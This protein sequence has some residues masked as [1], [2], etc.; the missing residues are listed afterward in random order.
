MIAALFAAE[1]AFYA[2]PLS[3]WRTYA[4]LYWIVCSVAVILSAAAVALATFLERDFRCLPHLGW[5][6]TAF[7]LPPVLIL[8][9]AGG[10]FLTHVDSEGLQQLADG[11]TLLRLDVGHGMF[12]LAHNSYPARQ[13]VLNCLPTCLLGP[14]LWAAR[15][16]NSAFYIASY[17]FFLSALA[18]H[19]R[20]RGSTDPLLFAAYC[21]SLIALGQYTLLNARQFEQTTMPIGATLFF[22]GAVL[23]FM[24]GPEPLRLLWVTWAFGFFPEC[25]T[26]ALGGF[27]LACAVLAYL[28]ILGRRWIFLP[29]A[30]YGLLCL[31]IA[32]QVA[33]NRDPGSLTAKFRM[34]LKHATAGD[35]AFRYSNGLRAVSGG[36]YSLLPAP[37]ALAVLAALCLALR[38]REYRYAA[39]CAWAGAVSFLSIALFGSNLNIPYFDIQRAMIIIPPLALGALFLFIRFMD[40]PGGSPSAVGTVKFLMEVSVAYMAFTGV[41]TVL[42]V[43]SFFGSEF[44]SEYDEVFA[45]VNALVTSPVAVPPLRIYLVPPLDA[46]IEPG[47]M[48]FAPEARVFRSEPPAGEKIAGAYVFSYI[49]KDAHDRSFDP[50]IPSYHLQPVI[51]MAR[52]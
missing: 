20:S 16:G 1:A 42:L 14:S 36:D 28:I 45:D 22:L 31:W 9:N 25:Y 43:R 2:A 52:E 4:G 40:S 7:F 39:V 23:Y 41:C 29:T 32:L 27:V 35:W 19:L 12:S 8:A 17:V 38:Y 34:G 18:S 46:I 37:L 5:Y 49:S 15:A 44:R 3:A 30:A 21:G 51:R 24:T 33:N 11:I 13:Y 6:A 10:I 47:L 26:P 50:F 48:Y